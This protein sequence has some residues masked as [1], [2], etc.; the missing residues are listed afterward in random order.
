MSP[1]LVIIMSKPLNTEK[2]KNQKLLLSFF[3]V[4]KLFPIEY[5]FLKKIQAYK[6][7]PSFSP[8][9]YPLCFSSLYIFSFLQFFILNFF[10]IV[11][12]ET[13]MHKACES[14]NLKKNT[15]FNPQ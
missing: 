5:F 6:T 1:L 15:F 2:K 10:K 3:D 14:Q 12:Y 13:N 9:L 8:P 4:P 11:N 7:S